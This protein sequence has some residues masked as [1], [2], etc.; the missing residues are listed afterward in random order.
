MSV[1]TNGFSF[2][3]ESIHEFSAEDWK[4]LFTDAEKELERRCDSDT[5]CESMAVIRH[6]VSGEGNTQLVHSA[7]KKAAFFWL[8]SMFGHRLEGEL[9]GIHN[10]CF[11]TDL[12]NY[13]PPFGFPVDDHVAYISARTTLAEF[14]RF[15]G[16]TAVSPEDKRLV[17]WLNKCVEKKS[18]LLIVQS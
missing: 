10:L 1:L 18:G 2:R 11:P 16:L 8:G 3:P 4:Q 5:V 14:Q 15:S 6:I 13:L 12:A 17:E 9:A 7:F